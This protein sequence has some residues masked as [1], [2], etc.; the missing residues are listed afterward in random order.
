VTADD[1]LRRSYR[2]L[3][4]AY[5]R[6]YRRARG[7]EVL[8]TLLD[9]AAVGQRR[10][11]FAEVRDLVGGGLRAR[12]R[13]PRNPAARLA[14]AAAALYAAVVGAAVGVQLSGHVGPPAEDRS[15]AAAMVAIPGQPRNLPGPPVA[16]DMLCPGPVE[17]DHVTAYRRP[18][19]HTDTVRIDYHPPHEQASTVVAQ[20]RHRLAGAGWQVSQVRVQSDG[21]V[22]FA[23]SNGRLDLD[24]TGWPQ[25]NEFTSP[26]TI[27]V[28]KSFS[29]SAVWSLVG[30]FV[31]GLLVG[32]LIASWALQRAWLHRDGRR[33]AV[34]AVASP[35]LVAGTGIGLMAIWGTVVF[36]I[37]MDPDSKSLKTPLVVLPD[38]ATPYWAA[39]ALIALSGLA[40][41]VLAVV[42]G[43]GRKAR[44]GPHGPE[45]AR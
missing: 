6:W 39:Q 5:P 28:N 17:G 41:L 29:T 9:D 16:C 7:A 31:G 25:P 26:V 4:L 20:A 33:W 35:F 8:T 24:V 23:A 22:S 32:W 2:R 14:A 19:D 43:P 12:M 15:V 38:L 34:A 42:P 40:A 44:Q 18:W 13:P 36:L 11:S 21:I 37:L 27:Q 10:A 3:M 30:G 45:V 1:R